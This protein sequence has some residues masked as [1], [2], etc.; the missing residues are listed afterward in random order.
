MDQALKILPDLNDE[1]LAAAMS[2]AFKA[3]SKCRQL[4]KAVCIFLIFTLSL[5]S[6]FFLSRYQ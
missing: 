1:P 6:H 2:F 3:A 4:S 5:P